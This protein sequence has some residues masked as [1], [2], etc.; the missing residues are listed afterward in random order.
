MPQTRRKQDR[1]IEPPDVPRKAE[2][3]AIAAP[4]LVDGAT[5]Q[6]AALA[7]V[8]FQGQAADDVLIEKAAL[9]H[10]LLAQT[11]I[12]AVQVIDARLETCDLSGA[13]WEK[14][15]LRRIELLGCRLMGIKLVD[16]SL[17]DAL[18]KDCNGEYGVFWSASFKSVRFERCTLRH[19]SFQDAN[20][21]GVVFDHCDLTNADLRGTKLHGADLR[22]ST[23][24]GINV[25]IK[26]L[27]GVIIDPTQAAQV[28]ALLGIVVKSD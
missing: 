26:E 20:L 3:E 1:T 28:V 22:G 2:L 5:W 11:E 13:V 10:V 14:A 21:S 16:A 7:H 23:L 24:M 12:S 4:Q 27:Q 9:N 19:A 18:I 6:K 25:G 8:N 17:D 15:H